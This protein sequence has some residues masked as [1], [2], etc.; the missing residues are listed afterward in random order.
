MA[1]CPSSGH[2]ADHEVQLQQKCNTKTTTKY[3][4]ILHLH[5][6]LSSRLSTYVF[7]FFSFLGMSH[8]VRKNYKKKSRSTSE[9]IKHN[10]TLRDDRRNFRCFS[11]TNTAPF[12]QRCMGAGLNHQDSGKQVTRFAVESAPAPRGTFESF[13]QDSGKQVTRFAMESA[14]APRGT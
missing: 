2:D 7:F 3:Q 13:H 6:K 5:P 11:C 14:P 1:L 12:S 9:S 8:R 4:D 10:T